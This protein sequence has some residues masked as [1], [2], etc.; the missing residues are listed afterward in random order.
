MFLSF[1]VEESN[2]RNI[3]IGINSF[4]VYPVGWCASNGY[5]LLTPAYRSKLKISP[6]FNMAEEITK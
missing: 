6:V 3:I 4:D 5:P 2:K 1:D